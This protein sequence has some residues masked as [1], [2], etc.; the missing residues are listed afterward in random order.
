MTE[1]RLALPDR[2]TADV[3]AFTMENGIVRLGFALKDSADYSL[4]GELIFDWAVSQGYKIIGMNRKKLSL[5]DIFVKLT[6]ERL[7]S[8]QHTSEEGKE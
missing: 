8:E 3:K 1:S 6:R 5:E 7:S 4:D 2:E